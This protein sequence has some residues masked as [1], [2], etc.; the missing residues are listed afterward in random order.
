MTMVHTFLTRPLGGDDTGDG[1][2]ATAPIVAC[3]RV[4]VAFIGAQDFVDGVNQPIFQDDLDVGRIGHIF[5]RITAESTTRSAILPRSMVPSSWA[6]RLN[7]AAFIVT[8]LQSLVIAH[9]QSEGA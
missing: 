9:T 3:A 6:A 8:H 2:S 5:K 7:F 4:N 1:V